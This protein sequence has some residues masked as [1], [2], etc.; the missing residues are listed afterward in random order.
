M[1]EIL[2][3]E[4]GFS[5][6]A[7]RR[8]VSADIAALWNNGWCGLAIIEDRSGRVR[9]RISTLHS[10]EYCFYSC[11]FQSLAK[12]DLKL[13][14]NLLESGSFKESQK[15]N[16]SIGREGAPFIFMAEAFQETHRK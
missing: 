1:L 7:I 6:I 10:G 12:E 11:D 3:P 8:T 13:I 4:H 9:L 14:L 2:L 16:F 15:A 5:N